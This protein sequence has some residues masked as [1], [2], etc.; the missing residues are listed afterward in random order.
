ML[1]N[2]LIV[3]TA[4][5]GTSSIYHYLKR[6]PEVFM[7]PIKEPMFFVRE[8]LE[9]PIRFLKLS[10]NLVQDWSSY[11][12]LFEK[13]NN[14]KAIG[15]ASPHY[16]YY[17]DTAIPEIKKHLKKDI[18]IIIILRNPIERSLSAYIHLVRD[19]REHLSF[20]KAL[21][22]EGKR[23]TSNNYTMLYFYK[24]VSLYYEQVRAYLENFSQV[25]ICL[26]D[27]LENDPLGLMK[28]LCKFLEVDSSFV[29]DLSI[30][31][32]I[33]GIP[34]SKLIHNF[35]TKPNIIKSLLKPMVKALIL[36]DKRSA[37]IERIK[38][39]NLRNLRNLKESEMKQET[40]QYL[41][42]VYTE[43]ILMLQGL[44]KRDLSNWLR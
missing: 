11:V 34:K 19:N 43:N 21:E 31:Y 27:D 23:R 18:K 1:P 12:R 5:A 17:Y 20:Q 40:K 35:I 33:S 3:G 14:E 8:K 15:E 2:F 36:S 29:M 4:K 10:T 37:L 39:R 22:E 9:K 16:L 41:L 32:N 25:K 42:E 38:S 7:S 44:I 13:V 6:H 30:K 24:S 28:G 26:F